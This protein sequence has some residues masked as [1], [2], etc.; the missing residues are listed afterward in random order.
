[1]MTILIYVALSLATVALGLRLLAPSKFRKINFYVKLA[2]ILVY[3]VCAAID[4]WLYGIIQEMKGKADCKDVMEYCSKKIKPIFRFMKM[5]FDIEIPPSVDVKQSYVII[6]NHQH[7]LDAYLFNQ[8]L[9]LLNFPRIVMKEELRGM[10]PV[11]KAF[12]RMN[13]VFVKRGSKQKAMSS[14]IEA[15]K[16][17]KVAN[18]SIVLFPEGTRHMGDTL[19]PFKVGG[20]QAAVSAQVPILPVVI[21]NYKNICQDMSEESI[22]KVKVLQPVATDGLGDDDVS[23]LM[24]KCRDAMQETF[25]VL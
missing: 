22:V 2:V 13:A 11:G 14:L 5:S 4:T 6:V 24:E 15:T 25:N 12:E 18:S 21:S 23:A 1:M 9:P 7:A 10:G 20:F 8:V 17:S 19:L 16:E 3:S